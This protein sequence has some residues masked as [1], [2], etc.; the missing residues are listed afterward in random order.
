MPK[1][2]FRLACIN[3]ML[4]SCERSK[5]LWF[6]S[7]RGRMAS[8]QD[9]RGTDLEGS[10][11][12]RALD[13]SLPRLQGARERLTVFEMPPTQA[14]QNKRIAVGI[15]RVRSFRVGS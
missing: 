4:V 3:P 7:G 13:A 14:E 10:I 5:A 6:E 11:R 9:L 2:S 8:V 15:R 12:S 1:L